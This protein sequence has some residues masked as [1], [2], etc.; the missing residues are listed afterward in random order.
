MKQLIIN[1][2]DFGLHEQV[3]RAIRIGHQQ[4]VITSATLMA[5]AAAFDDAVATANALPTLGVGVHLTLV[6]GERPVAEARQVPT[7]LDASGRFDRQYPAFLMRFMRGVVSKSEIR[8]ELTAQIEKILAAGIVPTHLD[9]HQHLHVFP[10]IS[11]IVLDLAQQY[12]IPAIR[13]P[14]EPYF[15]SGGYSYSLG[16]WGGRGA[17]TFLARR[18]KQL[19]VRRGLQTTDSFFGMLAGGN[20]NEALLR[21]IIEQLPDGSSEIM[22]HPGCDGQL[23]EQVCGW[24][25]SWEQELAAVCSADIR[26]RI[27]TKKIMLRKF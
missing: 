27:E 24:P 17:L 1:A 11:E 5:G 13:I 8:R 26:S 18:L 12:A 15:F 6:G 2:D 7:L 23:L 19:A 21:Q 9:S 4:G 25:Y 16:R 14:A 20:M 22:L 10:G 3:N